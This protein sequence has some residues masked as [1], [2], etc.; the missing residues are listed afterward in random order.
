MKKILLSMLSVLMIL[1]LFGCQ[2]TEE[3]IEKYLSNNECLKAYELAL[4]TKD[5]EIIERVILSWQKAILERE[6][7]DEN[8]VD[9]QKITQ[10]KNQDKFAENILDFMFTKQK[11]DNSQLELVN[12]LLN[13]V[14]EIYWA[15]KKVMNVYLI[16]KEYSN[17]E[18]SWIVE[19]RS[20]LSYEEYFSKEHIYTEKSNTTIKSD[21]E[22][23]QSEI[24]FDEYGMAVNLIFAA[25]KAK[26]QY[27]LFGD[28]SNY[29]Y[30][31][32]D[33]YWVYCILGKDLLR[34]SID[35]NREVLYSFKEEV[36]IH[37]YKTSYL[38][39]DTEFK[40]IDYDIALFKEIIDNNMYIHRMYLPEKKIDSFKLDLTSEEYTWLG[41]GNFE[42]HLDK[43]GDETCYYN[44]L[45]GQK[46][47][48]HILYYAVNPEYLSKAKMLKENLDLCYE[49]YR[50]YLYVNTEEE[51]KAEM[52]EALENPLSDIESVK[53]LKW[54]IASEYKVEERVNYD[55][56][57]LTG[58]IKINHLDPLLPEDGF[59]F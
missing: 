1:C 22:I 40:F 19:E 5:K 36:Q 46:S 39:Y 33:G 25:D 4:E 14:K 54:I 9:L 18:R 57:V 11:L 38:V 34:V 2:S 41:F 58:E 44:E 52:A 6:V 15:N 59:P 45:V 20:P 29:I 47:S 16:L 27:V 3:K 49:L 28:Y 23:L 48:N 53:K 8:F 56:N 10:I 43:Y 35:G 55:L 26:K 7:L 12:S 51:M 50:K 42:P 24:L 21:L 31:A 37:D 32:S 13:G 17:D 30:L